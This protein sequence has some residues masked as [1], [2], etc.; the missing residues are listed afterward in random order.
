M[1]NFIKIRDVR[2]DDHDAIAELAEK[3]KLLLNNLTPTI[4]SRT[5]NWLH[6]NSDTDKRVQILAQSLNRVTAHY[7]GVPF[8]IKWYEKNI[9]AVLASNLVVDENYRKQSLFF[10]LQKE[11]IKSYQKKGYSFAY[12]AIT[13]EGVLNPHLRVGWKSLGALYVFIRP[14]SLDITFK[15]LLNNSVVLNLIIF[16]LQIIQKIW[17]IVFFLK[18]N[19]IEIVEEVT[20]SNSISSLLDE[21]MKKK[22]ICS[23]RTAETL[24]WRFC[25]FKDRSYSIFVSYKNSAP[26]GYLVVRFMQMKKLSCLAIVDIVILNDKKNVFNA[27][28]KKSIDFARKR[29]ADL[30]STALTDHDQ[31]K[32][33]FYSAGFFKSQEKFII[34]GHFPKVGDVKN[35]DFTFSDFH[36]N[37]FDHDYV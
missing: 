15:K 20:F 11:F 19:N 27:L 17:D 35:S 12:G 31:L 29:K 5:L 18:R 6:G 3:N 4:F 8:K 25:D 21:W 22:K 36:I 23:I 37:W 24:N 13:R 16:P 34:V 28:M 33:S 7:G 14:I 10:S 9:S 30:I 32:S 1:S 2:D 26:T